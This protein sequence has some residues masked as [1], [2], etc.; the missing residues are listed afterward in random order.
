MKTVQLFT[1]VLSVSVALP[2]LARE[3]VSIDGMLNASIQ[4]HDRVEKN[5]LGGADAVAVSERG[6]SDESGRLQ[7]RPEGLGVAKIEIEIGHGTRGIVQRKS[8]GADQLIGRQVLSPRDMASDDDFD[9]EVAAPT[10]IAKKAPAKQGSA[11]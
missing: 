10:R 11:N 7:K 2:A 1:L 9:Q 8:A 5:F 3:R 4:E 6:P